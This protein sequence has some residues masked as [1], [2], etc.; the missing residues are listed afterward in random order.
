[1]RGRAWCCGSMHAVALR[2]RRPRAHLSACS[3]TWLAAS[4]A[5]R[6]LMSRC[7]ATKLATP[8]V[9][10]SRMGVMEI[11]GQRGG[12]GGGGGGVNLAG[13][14]VPKKGSHQTGHT[15]AALAG[16]CGRGSLSEGR[17]G[18]VQQVPSDATRGLRRGR[19]GPTPAPHRAAHLAPEGG[20]VAA[21]DED[22]GHHGAPLVHGGSNV[23]QDHRVGVG[24]L[25]QGVAAPQH[26][27][28]AVACRVGAPRPGRAAGEG[29][30]CAGATAAA[31]QAA[32]TRIAR[33]W[34]R[35]GCMQRQAACSA[36]PH[37]LPATP[38]TAPPKSRHAQPGQDATAQPPH[39]SCAQRRRWPTQWGCP[40]ARGL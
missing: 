23:G 31:A 9:A 30:S 32:A 1:M 29:N 7:T 6:W 19:G 25:Q 27:L 17:G 37:L 10:A 36:P 13:G 11:W 18:H 22:L 21:V 39:L 24:P 12:C 4:T 2:A 38:P 26:S 5:L 8:P 40:A 15:S 16:Q 3:R 34:W 28:L 33:Q 14:T 35:R 20:A